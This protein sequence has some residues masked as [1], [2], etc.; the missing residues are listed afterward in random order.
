MFKRIYLSLP[1]FAFLVGCQTVSTE[2][3][4][5]R[6]A[7]YN[8]LIQKQEIIK[9][10]DAGKNQA[11]PYI[12]VQPVNKKEKCLIPY[13]ESAIKQGN[14]V[15]WE[16]PCQDGRSF[17]IGRMLV[18]GANKEFFDSIISAS[19]DGEASRLDT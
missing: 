10:R 5:V 4:P 15:F 9:K 13:T 19:R 17:G 7:N 11:T 1:L 18:L 6:Q 2:W 3:E 12:W 16:G 8:D 14:Q